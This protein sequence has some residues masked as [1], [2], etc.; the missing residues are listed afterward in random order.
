MPFLSVRILCLALQSSFGIT[1]AHFVSDMLLMFAN[2][3]SPAHSSSFDLEN[4]SSRSFNFCS[5]LRSLPLRGLL[6]LDDKEVAQVAVAALP[7]ALTG[8]LLL[9]KPSQFGDKGYLR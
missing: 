9:K 8:L 7:M 2:D 4:P 5:T 1:A 3:V 6:H